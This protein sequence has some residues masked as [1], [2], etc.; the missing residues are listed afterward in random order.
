MA[1]IIVT[2]VECVNEH[3]RP[4]AVQITCHG[5]RRVCPSPDPQ[6][7]Y[8]PTAKP[9]SVHNCLNTLC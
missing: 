7:I 2:R 9:Q 5:V 1:N 4:V 3:V 6:C 8:S